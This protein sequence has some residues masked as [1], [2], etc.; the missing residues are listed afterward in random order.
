M[1]FFFKTP[2]YQVRQGCTWS[3]NYKS[4]ASSSSSSSDRFRIFSK[5]SERIFT[6]FLQ[7][8]CQLFAN[9]FPT[10]FA[11]IFFLPEKVHCSRRRH[12]GHERV[13]EDVDSVALSRKQKPVLREHFAIIL[14]VFLR[15]Q[16]S[17]SY[18]SNLHYNLSCKLSLDTSD[19]DEKYP[20]NV[21]SE[22]NVCA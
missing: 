11:F 4:P 17:K 20:G 3:R 6:N 12:P 18:C 19:F 2:F 13:Q 16:M 21:A 10:I 7:T 14:R 1:F 8:F 15:C 22:K 5:C 9:F